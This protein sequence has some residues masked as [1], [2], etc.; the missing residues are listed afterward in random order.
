MKPLLLALMMIFMAPTMA[1]AHVRLVSSVPADGTVLES[2]PKTITLKFSQSVRIISVTLVNAKDE[3]TKTSDLP[4]GM[5]E[6]AVV[7]IP[8]LAA[9]DYVVTWRG[10]SKDMHAMSGTIK[11]TVK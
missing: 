7:D 2:S 1:S 8:T 9:G 6:E 10:A 5:V 11:F 4:K 3:K